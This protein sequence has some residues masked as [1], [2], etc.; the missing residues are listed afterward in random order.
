MKFGL[1]ASPR[2]TDH[3]TGD[4]VENPFRNVALLKAFE[5][6]EWPVRPEKIPLRAATDEELQVFHP[7]AYVGQIEQMGQAGGGWL[8]PDTFVSP[9]SPG[10]GREAVGAAIDLARQVA[11]GELTRGF[12]CVRPPGHHATPNRPMGFCLFS[13]MAL[14][15]RACREVGKVLI[16]DWDVH[17]GNGT[18][19]CL[20]EDPDTCFV[21][22]HQYPFYPGTGAPDERGRGP[23]AGLTYNLPLPAGC[24]DAEHLM[25][26]DRVVAPIIKEYQPDLILVSA[27]YDSHRADPLGGMRVT[28]EGFQSLARRVLATS[29]EVP[30]QG[31]VVGLLEGGYH[32]QKLADSVVATIST[33]MGEPGA[34]E[35]VPD[36]APGFEDFLA[37]CRERFT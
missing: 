12:A 20:Y 13:T 31:K 1:V 11:E 4:H 14:V 24:G 19:D 36:A 26:Y 34:V 22:M 7:P 27:G 35:P 9:A 18:Q 30:A 6:M 32:P 3:D 5:G 15:A 8:D 10:V 28:T 21:S 2:F 33:W 37:Q 23:G 25:A 17:H 16:F 29:Y